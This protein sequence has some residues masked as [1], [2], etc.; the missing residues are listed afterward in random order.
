MPAGG[1]QSIERMSRSNL[2]TEL[3]YYIKLDIKSTVKTLDKY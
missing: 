1:E 3:L 2:R